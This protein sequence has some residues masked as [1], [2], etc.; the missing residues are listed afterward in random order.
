MASQSPTRTPRASEAKVR[1][2]S[3]L[4]KCFLY[5]SA[6]HSF[7]CCWMIADANNMSWTWPNPKFGNFS[8]HFMTKQRTSSKTRQCVLQDWSR[9]TPRKACKSCEPEGPNSEGFGQ[10]L[11]DIRLVGEVTVVIFS[12]FSE[13]ANVSWWLSPW[14]RT[15]TK[16]GFCYTY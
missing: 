11:P 10:T 4:D 12:H 7:H 16:G 3:I 14:L 5:T 13:D 6:V 2:T 8:R 1:R 9:L 15:L